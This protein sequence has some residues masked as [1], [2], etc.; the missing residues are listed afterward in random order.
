MENLKKQSFNTKESEKKSFVQNALDKIEVAG[1]KLPHPVTIFALLCVGIAIIS[2]IAAATGLAVEADILNRQTNEIETQLVSAVSLLSADGIKYMLENAVTN[3]TSFA[4]LG[5]VLVGMLGIGVF[6]SS[7][8]IG[9]ILKKV[10]SVTPAKFVVPVVALL[11]I[12]SNI[13][14]DAGY[15]I[16]IPLAALVFMAYGKH[17]LAGIATAFAGVSG[18]FSANLLIGTTDPMLAGITNEAAHIIDA[19]VNVTATANYFFMAASTIMITIVITLLTTKII[20]PRLGEWNGEFHG[21]NDL[22]NMTAL[23]KKALK[24]ANATLLFLVIA[25]IAIV[26]MPNSVL[27]NLEA[28]SFVNSIIDHST[29]MNG[30]IPI[31]S[32]MFFI[33]SV[34][35]GKIAGTMK[36]EKEVCAHMT[37]SM[38]TM[39]GYLVLAFVASQFISYFS[40]T[41]LATII[42]VKGAT[43]LE[44]LKIGSIPLMLGFILITAFINLFM[45][46]ASAKWAIMAPVFIPMF[47]QLN[48]D[49]A[50]VQAAY[51]VADST[52]NIISPL[53]TYFAM[54]IVFMQAYKKDTG[55]GT[56]VSL[57]IPYSMSLLVCWSVLLVIWML[58]GLPIGF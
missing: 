6:E 10:V 16:L 19:S 26:L 50:L 27:R 52:T 44:T 12:M 58:T 14:S 37:K 54:V 42:A 22:Q 17:P 55:I 25:L 34:V 18:G 51:R 13:A 1:N 36:N 46:S 20:E 24:R 2:A 45:G 15:V 3:F 23:E 53:M 31:I 47:M 39:G 33:P 32:I 49:P 56:V 4:P 35:Y 28:T 7:G 41:N 11:G 38:S 8:Y 57:M 21:G 5:V 40:Y 29:L 30:L 48:L 43:I 9:T